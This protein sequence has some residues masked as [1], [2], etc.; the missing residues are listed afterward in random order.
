MAAV[1]PQYQQAPRQGG[2]QIYAAQAPQHQVTAAAQA[3]HAQQMQAAQAAAGHRRVGGADDKNGSSA[4]MWGLLILFLIL[5]VVFIVWFLWCNQCKTRNNCDDP[6]P[7]KRK[8]C[9]GCHKS[10]DECECDSS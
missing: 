3:A 2:Q 7:P 1:H 5:I 9:G 6:C 10:Q 8:R 4:W